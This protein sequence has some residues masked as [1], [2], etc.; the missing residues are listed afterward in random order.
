MSQREPTALK[1]TAHPTVPTLPSLVDSTPR[2]TPACFSGKEYDCAIVNS[3]PASLQG[4]ARGPPNCHSPGDT[5]LGSLRASRTSSWRHSVRVTIP[6][7]GADMSK[8]IP[9][10]DIDDLAPT[11]SSATFSIGDDKQ[12]GVSDNKHDDDHV[13]ENASAKQSATDGYLPSTCNQDANGAP[14]NEPVVPANVCG[15]SPLAARK[16]KPDPNDQK[17][18]MT[19]E[20]I[21][22]QPIPVFNSATFGRKDPTTGKDVRT[23]RR[24]RAGR[25]APTYAEVGLPANAGRPPMMT[26]ASSQLPLHQGPPPPVTMPRLPLYPISDNYQTLPNFTAPPNAQVGVYPPGYLPGHSRFIYAQ[27][28]PAFHP[29]YGGITSPPFPVYHDTLAQAIPVWR[30]YY[31]RLDFAPTE[32]RAMFEQAPELSY[33]QQ[34]VGY[35]QQQWDGSFGDASLIPTQSPPTSEPKQ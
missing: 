27:Q 5:P 24:T 22:P 6:V 20:S 29:L 11:S 21:S 23:T 19:D 12:D 34:Q 9:Y 28:D 17:R 31:G 2:D 16:V 26:T 30:G 33:M 18:S 8:T 10:G 14:M 25:R 32:P 3:A 35:A 1:E 4:S 7:K 13:E 15:A